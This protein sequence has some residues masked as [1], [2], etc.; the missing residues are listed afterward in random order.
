MIDRYYNKT[1]ITLLDALHL[2]RK[3]PFKNI[4]KWLIIQE[5]LIKRHIYV[6][7]Q[8]RSLKSEIKELNKLR[9]SNTGRRLTRAESAEIKDKI[10]YYE[11]L[12]EEYNRVIKIF[13]SIG[14]GIAFTFLHKLDIKPQNFKESA[15]F[16]SN[17]VGLKK[18][19]RILRTAFKNNVVAILNDI[20]SV[21]KF[22]D[23]ILVTK[24]GW[25]PIES[26]TSNNYN[27]RIK[28]QQEK[29]EKLFKYLDDDVAENLHETGKVMQRI[30]QSVPEE[31]HISKLNRLIVKAKAKG[32]AYSL[33][34][35]GLLY[36]VTYKETKNDVEG[37]L[38][39]NKI[40]QP[41]VHYLNSNK[42]PELGY[43]PFSLSFNKSSTYWEFLIGELII[44]IFAD[45]NEV[46]KISKTYGYVLEQSKQEG[47][48]LHFKSEKERPI[49]AFEMSHHYFNRIFF[50][51]VSLKWLLEESF[52]R[53]ENLEKTNPSNS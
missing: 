7:N 46:I 28:R 2:A 10:E 19:K 6:E 3:E 36:Y 43:Y 15:G 48:F 20:T 4:K 52:T 49:K 33:V 26:K 51:F 14:D 35:K 38:V 17:K 45:L 16:I 12:I 34:E 41:Y 9:K 47:F 5:I 30:E 37:I 53:F 39:K 1:I 29:A 23:L 31:N 8:I 11:Y 18:E 13:K 44:L 27:E 24:E 32:E 25:A 40:Y 50:E 22:T 42:F 21:L